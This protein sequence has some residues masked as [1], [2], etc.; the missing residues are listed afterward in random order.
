[1]N[2]LD[3]ADQELIEILNE[4]A[5]LAEQ[6]PTTLENLK[7]TE[8]HRDSFDE[9]DAFL[10]AADVYIQM[11]FNKREEYNEVME[12]LGRHLFKKQPPFNELADACFLH[13]TML[14]NAFRILTLMY[15]DFADRMSQC[16]ED[17]QMSFSGQ[18]IW[19]GKK[20]A[21]AMLQALSRLQQTQKLLPEESELE[22]ELI[23]A[24]RDQEQ[25]KAWSETRPT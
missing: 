17:M 24:L 15:E 13:F 16:E 5:E 11:L 6:F 20:G 14:G 25:D 7:E 3:K 1:M 8:P 22:E 12:K 9:A 23:E 10:G 21:E 19:V 18:D 4:S 2:K